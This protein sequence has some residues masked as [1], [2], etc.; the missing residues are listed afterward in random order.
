M[1]Q[2]DAIDLVTLVVEDQDRAIDFYV[3]KV[4]LNLVQD[5]AYGE[6][7][8][9]VEVAPPGSRTK[10]TLKT[11]EMFEDE[12]A[13]HRRALV[14]AS[15]QVT[16]LVDDCWGIYDRLREDGVRFDDEPVDLP[17]G[18]SVTARDPSGN[19]VVFTQEASG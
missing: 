16:L 7:E 10:I 9:W 2:V 11:P 4:G 3:D 6:G 8:R 12:E 19:Q 14:G 18:T 5:E 15:P 1:G 17:W 13:R